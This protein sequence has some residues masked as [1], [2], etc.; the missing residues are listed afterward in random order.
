MKKLLPWHKSIYNDN[1][2]WKR[3]NTSGIMI[4]EI[5]CNN[6]SIDDLF[7]Y[8]IRE[9]DTEKFQTS[10]VERLSLQEC[11]SFVDKLLESKG[12]L[13]LDEKYTV[14]L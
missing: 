10:H 14:M 11:F 12:Y 2:R 3:R 1:V 13:F 6:Y 7:F 5:G 9:E 8:S 4:A